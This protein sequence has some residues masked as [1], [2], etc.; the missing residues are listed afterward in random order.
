MFNDSSNTLMQMVGMAQIV[1]DEAC[2][3]LCAA[4][5]PPGGLRQ[6]LAHALT[7]LRQTC[8]AQQP[9]T[10][11]ELQSLTRVN[12]ALEARVVA[13]ER[14]LAAVPPPLP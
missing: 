2:Q 9:A 13:L 7:W 8:R 10:Q 1:Q 11:R 3:A 14:Q 12:Q 5:L 4:Q 6:A